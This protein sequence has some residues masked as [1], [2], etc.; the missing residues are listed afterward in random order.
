M[1]AVPPLADQLFEICTCI[2]VLIFGGEVIEDFGGGMDT[3]RRCANGSFG[4][5]PFS[6][7]YYSRLASLYAYQGSSK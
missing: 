5:W 7:I 3:S 2:E 6:S 1:T 4:R